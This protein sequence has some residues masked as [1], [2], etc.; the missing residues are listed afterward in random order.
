VHSVCTDYGVPSGASSVLKVQLHVRS[1]LD[2]GTQPLAEY[3][4]AGR[5]VLEGG[6]KFVV[7]VCTVHQQIGE[8]VQFF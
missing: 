7:K 8:T 5:G 4:P 3:E 2:N 1:L 6:S